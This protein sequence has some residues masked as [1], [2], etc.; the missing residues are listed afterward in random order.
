[1]V[2]DRDMPSNLSKANGGQNLLFGNHVFELKSKKEE[3]MEKQLLEGC[4]VDDWVK[5]A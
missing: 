2:A 5:K 4:D 1:M 3:E